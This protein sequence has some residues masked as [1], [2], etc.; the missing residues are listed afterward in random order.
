MSE[1]R[2]TVEQG[3]DSEYRIIDRKDAT[4]NYC[5]V[6]ARAPYVLGAESGQPWHHWIKG[7]AD[8]Y[9]ASL[10]QG[11]SQPTETKED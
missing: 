4:V 1:P 11:W 2:F 8:A 10:N 6:E 5:G 7:I 3:C 9:C